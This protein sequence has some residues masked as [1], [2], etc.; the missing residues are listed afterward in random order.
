[1]KDSL[2]KN[3][4]L[5]LVSHL[6]P[7]ALHVW[8]FAEK[9]RVQRLID[10]IQSICRKMHVELCSVSNALWDLP[11]GSYW[12]STAFSLS[13]LLLYLWKFKGNAQGYFPHQIIVFYLHCKRLFPGRLNRGAG[14]II[15]RESSW[16]GPSAVMCEQHV[17]HPGSLGLALSIYSLCTALLDQ[18]RSERGH[19]N[20]QVSLLFFSSCVSPQV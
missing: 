10:S 20:L 4:T 18:I 16:L 8:Q 11:L 5:N 9:E 15:T 1:M 12:V 2:S 7:L 14:V 13:L 3:V 19:K 17:F 6:L